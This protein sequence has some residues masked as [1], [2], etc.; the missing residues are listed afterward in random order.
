MPWFTYLSLIVRLFKVDPSKGKAPR[1]PDEVEQD[2]PQDL[3]DKA[4]K[5]LKERVP[6]TK[7]PC[8]L[9]LLNLEALMSRIFTCRY[10]KFGRIL[11]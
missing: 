7:N 1:A 10:S 5:R 11:Q 2:L 9:F 6:I 3:I 8:S 4:R